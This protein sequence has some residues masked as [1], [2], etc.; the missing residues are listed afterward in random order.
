VPAPAP[1]DVDVVVATAST[2]DGARAVEDAAGGARTIDAGAL[3]GE[4]LAAGPALAWACALDL[5]AAGG[6][7]RVRILSSGLDGRLGDVVLAGGA[8]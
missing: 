3:F 2:E 4:C 5:V 8:R 7:R 1:A 6:A